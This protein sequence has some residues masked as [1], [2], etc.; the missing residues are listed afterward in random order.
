LDPI[1]QQHKLLREAT[2]FR[3]PCERWITLPLM[4]PNFVRRSIVS[5]CLFVFVFFTFRVSVSGYN[6]TEGNLPLEGNHY[7]WVMRQGSGL[8][9]RIDTAN[10]SRGSRFSGSLARLMP[11]P[12]FRI[13]YLNSWNGMVKHVGD[14]CISYDVFL[15]TLFY[16]S[17]VVWPRW[18]QPTCNEDPLLLLYVPTMDDNRLLVDRSSCHYHLMFLF[19][20]PFV[21]LVLSVVTMARAGQW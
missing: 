8:T 19:G 5:F 15:V 11:R 20:F 13:A 10:E 3:F 14:M 6:R 1:I 17:V 21:A 18:P 2:V 7:M 16:S 9:R 12:F 4:V